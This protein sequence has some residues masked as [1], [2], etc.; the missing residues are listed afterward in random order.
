MK[1]KREGYKHSEHLGNKG[2]KMTIV[3]PLRC[4]NY[5]S[6]IMFIKDNMSNIKS[7][8]STLCPKHRLT[9]ISKYVK[10]QTKNI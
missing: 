6:R 7:N 1:K 5:A 10:E 9:L 4:C 3:C 2:H 8:H